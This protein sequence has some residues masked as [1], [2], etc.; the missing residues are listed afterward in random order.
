M[1]RTDDEESPQFVRGYFRKIMEIIYDGGE[2]PASCEPFAG[3]DL[4]L[5]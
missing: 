2:K 3:A 1:L 5:A 4:E